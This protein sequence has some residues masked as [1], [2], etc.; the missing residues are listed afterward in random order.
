MADPKNILLGAFVGIET[1]HFYSAFLPSIFT[2]RTF[3]RKDP[4]ALRALRQGEVIA[5]AFALSLGWTVSELTDDDKPLLF[6]ILTAALM[7]LVYESAMRGWLDSPV[8]LG[9]LGA[10]IA[11]P[12]P[13]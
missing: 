6:A 8:G 7:I 4:D 13:P 2:I 3:A 5:T 10:I 12:I 9:V 1:A 11:A